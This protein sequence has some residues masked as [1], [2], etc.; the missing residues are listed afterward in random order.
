MV[1]ACLKTGRLGA[2]MLQTAAQSQHNAALPRLDASN[3]R[4]GQSARLKCGILQEAHM[5]EIHS[6]PESISHPHKMICQTCREKS[7]VLPLFVWGA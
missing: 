4:Q 1:A 5:N 6:L 3:D 2:I 7:I